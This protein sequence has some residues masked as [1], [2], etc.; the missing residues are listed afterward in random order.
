MDHGPFE[1]SSSRQCKRCGE[2]VTLR[3]SKKSGRHYYVNAEGTTGVVGQF[4]STHCPGKSKL[5]IE[6]VFRAPI[7]EALKQ[8]APERN[9][10]DLAN[11]IAAY[12]A[13]RLPAQAM[14]EARVREI[15]KEVAGTGSVNISVSVKGSD[16]P[17]IEVGRQHH[18]FPTLL[19]VMGRR[20]NLWMSGPAGS[21]K[22]SAAHAAAKALSLE[23]GAISVGPQTTQSAL[24]GYMDAH[25]NYVHT[26]FRR[27]Y[28]HGGVF[29]FDEIDRGNPGVLTA[30]NQA[31][32]NGT[33]AFP[34]AMIPRHEQFIAVAAANTFGTG[35]SRE[36]VGA[37]QL[38]AAT[39]DRF[40]M[41]AWDYDESLEQD[42]AEATYKAAG[43][44]NAVVLDRWIV[45]VRRAR[46]KAASLK[47]RHVV[48]PR[49][50]IIGAD[51][52]AIGMDEATVSALVLWKGLDTDT[53]ERLS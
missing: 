3:R 29:L 46:S 33:C 47:V 30:L 44:T 36:Y 20:R 34:D 48:S 10:N 42:I 15:A 45:K 37:L 53:I 22:T 11:I 31:I 24:F 6:N 5:A 50:S 9:G 38:D 32:E 23:F 2:P 49:A 16:A 4:H 27:R 17:P 18:L 39:L 21:G 1:D 12:V 52:L 40:V 13:Q 26:E 8:E 41:L 51:L 35:A 7:V 25:G 43:G 19:A 28:E 14:D